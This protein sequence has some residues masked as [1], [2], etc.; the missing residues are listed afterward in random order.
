MRADRL[1]SILMLLQSR[2]RMTARVLADELMVSERTIYRDV[3][4]LCSS[5]VPI[6][7]EHGPGGGFALLDSYRTNLTG[8][9]E[10]EL[11]AL[12]MLSVPAPLERLGVSQELRSALLKLSAALPGERRA[13]ETLVQQRFLLDWAWFHTDEPVPNLNVLQQGVWQNRRVILSYLLPFGVAV[14]AQAVDPYGLVAKA[15]AWFL[16]AARAGYPVVYRVSSLLEARLSDETF[17]RRPDFDLAAFWRAWCLGYE[18]ERESYPVLVRVSPRIR[19]LL[20]LYF[21]QVEL[22][23]PAAG[24]EWQTITLRFESLE[25][26]RGKL[27]AAGRAVEVLEPEALRCSLVDFA[28]QIVEFYG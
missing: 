22:P 4:A 20:R 28:Q 18:Q 7:T 9:T 11:R 17:E 5:G 21:G 6:Y 3:E 24:D 12:F 23:A 14:E 15:G 16:V 1:I 13:N 19:P 26:A 10:D 25:A 8:M 27:L 2:G